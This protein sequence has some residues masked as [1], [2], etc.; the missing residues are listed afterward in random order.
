[1]DV[2]QFFVQKLFTY[3]KQKMN[4]MKAILPLIIIIHHIVP[5]GYNDL[6]A[7]NVI[8]SWVTIAMYIFFAMSG[9]G[10]VT[11]YLKNSEYLNGFLPKSLKK[12]FVPYF[13]VMFLFV[14]YRWCNG[15]DQIELLVTKG[16][17]SFVPTSWYIYVLSY[18]YIFFFFIFRYVKANNFVKVLLVCALVYGYY[19]I[20]PYLGVSPWRYDKCPAFCIG[21]LF[22]LFNKQILKSFTRWHVLVVL[23]CLVLI[24]PYRW[25]IAWRIPTFLPLYYATIFFLVMYVIGCVKEFRIVKFLSSISLEMFLVQYIPIYIFV[26]NLQITSTIYVVSFV[27]LLDILL[28]YFIHKV[29]EYIT[30]SKLIF[31]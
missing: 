14:I 22:A 31:K 27:I 23:S 5:Y 30:T 7:I 9:Y 16:L 21:M 17:Y 8:S 25:A 29:I 24:H 11:S 10:L 20:A 12:L 15:I 1:M 3:D 4:V 28:A 19:L 13:I 18:F 2:K 26:Q 6:S